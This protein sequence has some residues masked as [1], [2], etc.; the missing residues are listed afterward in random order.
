[1]PVLMEAWAF[2]SG[3]AGWGMIHLLT[4]P[5]TMLVCRYTSSAV[6]G[7]CYALLIGLTASLLVM[8]SEFFRDMNP[9]DWVSGESIE[10]KFSFAIL[11]L[12]LAPVSLM[13]LMTYV[14]LVTDRIG[15]S[16]RSLTLLGESKVRNTSLAVYFLWLAA[17]SYLWFDQYQDILAKSKRYYWG[18]AEELAEEIQGRPTLKNNL[19]T[20]IDFPP[21]AGQA[22]RHGTAARAA[23][24]T[25]V[26]RFSGWIL[27]L[28]LLIPW[29]L[30]FPMVKTGYWR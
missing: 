17:G 1:M 5:L 21:I 22:G 20:W 24:N 14:L 18:S 12:V 26:L 13:T 8:Y 4:L 19:Y 15:A 2:M 30:V 3:M 7:V 25:H 28:W 6:T 10:Q 11:T 27:G 9:R 16:W 23:E 29:L